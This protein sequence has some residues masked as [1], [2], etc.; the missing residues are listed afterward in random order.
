MRGRLFACM[1]LLG[2]AGYADVPKPANAFLE[3][4]T[5]MPP[6]VRSALPEILLIGDSIRLQYCETVSNALAGVALVRYPQWNTGNTQT[7]LNS[8]SRLRG[9]VREPKV[10]QFNC[11]HWDVSHWDGDEESLTSPQEYGRNIRLIIRRL[12][13]YYPS[14]TIVFATTTPT[15]PNGS[16]GRNRRTRDE[17]R[18]Y[19][20]I[21]VA[22]A[23][24]EGAQIND[25]FAVAESW[26]AE[27]Y[28]DYCH[29]KKEAAERLGRVVAERLK[30]RCR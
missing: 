20:D 2:F 26:P 30:A 13:K 19:N 6:A 28:Q 11:G 27:D 24:A 16:L 4:A 23:K 18:T 21:A 29:Y 9:L 1:C 8:L 22:V 10:V 14:A 12:R 25:L 5:S 17:V 15:N 3:D 7:V